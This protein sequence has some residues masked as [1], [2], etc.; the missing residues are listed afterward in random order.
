[1]IVYGL[2]LR[3][4]VDADHIAAIDNVTRKLMQDNERP[5]A[6]GFFFALGH[7]AVITIVAAAV[8]GAA[9]MLGRFQTY[10]AIGGTIGTSVSAVFLLAIAWINFSTFLSV[11]KSYRHPVDG[12]HVEEVATTFSGG[13]GALARLFQPLFRMVSKSW[14]MLLLGALLGLGFDT[15]TE[16]AMFGISAQQMASGLPFAA[17]LAFPLLFAAGMSLVDTADGVLMLG[18]YEWAFF[19]PMRKLYYNMTI[20]LV[21]VVV[22]LFVGGVEALA[23][24]N[25]L[26]GQ[27]GSFWSAVAH[28]NENF[29]ELGLVIVAIFL[30]AWLVSYLIYRI[31]KRDCVEPGISTAANLPQET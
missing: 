7:S 9:A 4:A 14:H 24:L 20:T 31:R 30:L 8:A 13:T 16:I 11:Y 18:A 6:V 21:S 5:V 15:A 19:K 12:R 1:L 22:A 26:L 29:N 27:S 17:I 28:L 3:H 23:L 10:S 2:G 25:G